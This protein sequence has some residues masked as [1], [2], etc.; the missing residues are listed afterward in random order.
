MPYLKTLLTVASFLIVCSTLYGQNE[1]SASSKK[2]PAIK[3]TLTAPQKPI[4][5]GSTVEV[6]VT[7]TNI[8][9]DA[10]TYVQQAVADHGGFDYKFT[11]RGSKGSEPPL[12]EFHQALKGRENPKYLT[13]NTPLSGSLVYRQFLP[14]QSFTSTVDL[15]RL[16]DLRKPGT[17]TVQAK[18]FDS[19]DKRTVE[20]NVVTITVIE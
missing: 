5:T 18:V 12:T 6:S 8:S 1:S 20:S 17:Y 13:R 14:A 9:N 10:F 16:Y 4:K 11:V 19:H 15:S 2:Q 3:V 7:I